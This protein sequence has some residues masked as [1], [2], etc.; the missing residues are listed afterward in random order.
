MKAFLKFSY[1]FIIV[2]VLTGCIGENYDFSPPT[3]TLSSK[4]NM[5]S[6]ELVEA[7]INWRG[8]GNNPIDKETKNILTLAHQQ[9]PIYFFAGEKVDMLFE[10]ADFKTEQFSVSLWQ[11]D[12]KLDLEVTDLSFYLPKEKG[13][14]AIE[15]ILQTDRGD[16]QY[17][18][19]VVIK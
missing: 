1:G 5:K 4:S 17:V 18:G 7:N 13:D 16:A 14:Y 2:L 11:N 15:A 6:V 12:K 3:V 9:Q 19:N 8:E 10:H